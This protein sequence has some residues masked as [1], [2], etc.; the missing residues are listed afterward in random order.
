MENIGKIVKEEEH[1]LFFRTAVGNGS[2]K[3]EKF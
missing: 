1:K 3:E 2:Y